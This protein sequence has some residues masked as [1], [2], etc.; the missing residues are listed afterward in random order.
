MVRAEFSLDYV[1]KNPHLISKNRSKLKSKQSIP[2]GAASS[3]LESGGLRLEI[4][5]YGDSRMPCPESP[6]RSHSLQ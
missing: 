4:L 1:E 5:I 2:K 3:F 6:L